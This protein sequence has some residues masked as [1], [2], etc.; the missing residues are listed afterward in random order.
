M[1]VNFYL[2]VREHTHCDSADIVGCATLDALIIR[3]GEVFGSAFE[4]FLRADETC[5]FLV[6][7]RSIMSTG[8]FATPLVDDDIVDVLPAVEAG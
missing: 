3:L 7:S 2:S 1:K 8:G 5:F 6:N 4:E